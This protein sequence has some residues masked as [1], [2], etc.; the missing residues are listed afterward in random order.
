[1]NFTNA[2]V[3]RFN[4][5][6]RG[7]CRQIRAVVAGN[8]FRGVPMNHREGG[9]SSGEWEGEETR[10]EMGDGEERRGR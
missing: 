7:K 4:H 6:G 3:S 9:L 10:R 8:F 5:T 1:M 2:T